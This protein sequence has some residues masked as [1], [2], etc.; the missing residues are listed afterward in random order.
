[1]GRC[2]EGNDFGQESGGEFRRFL[3]VEICQVMSGAWPEQRGFMQLF[4]KS[5]ENFHILM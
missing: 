1:M 2:E 3:V 5:S 4:Q